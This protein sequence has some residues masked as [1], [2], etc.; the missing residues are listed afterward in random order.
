[1]IQLHKRKT[2]TMQLLVLELDG[3]SHLFIFA[4]CAAAGKT[5]LSELQLWKLLVIL[6]HVI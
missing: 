5:F 3:E 4:L 2:T 1:M 6:L